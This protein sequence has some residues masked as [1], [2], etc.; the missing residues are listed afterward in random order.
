METHFKFIKKIKIIIIITALLAMGNQ[1][2]GGQVSITGK[3]TKIENNTIT[4]ETIKAET[5]PEGSRVDLFFEISEGQSIEV[6]QWK[7]SSRGKGV[8]FATPVDVTG[9]PLKGMTAKISYSEEKNRVQVTRQDHHNSPP[10]SQNDDTHEKKQFVYN[11]QQYVDEAKKIGDD[12]TKNSKKYSKEKNQ[13]LQRQLVQNVKKAVAADNAEAYYLLA[14]L[15]QNGIGEISRSSKKMV[16]NLM[17]SAKKGHDKAQFMLGDMYKRGDEVIKDKE[18]AIYWFQKAA[19]QGHQGAKMELE[20]LEPQIRGKEPS[21]KKPK[22]QL[23]GIPFPEKTAKEYAEAGDKYFYKKS[24]KMA[25]KEYEQCARMGN[26]GCQKMLGLF[27]NNGFGVEKDLN[28]ARKF[29]EDSARQNNFEAIYNLGLLYANGQGV[30]KN[31]TKARELFL[32]SA[33]LGYPEAQFNLGV[34]YY[35]GMGVKKR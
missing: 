29:Y 28:K 17:M 6:G 35:N 26:A 8:V 4:I 30:K 18:K 5:I 31:M 1:S 9:P 27:Y 34:L 22:G 20:L 23:L 3:V 32:Q 25:F 10:I 2:F 33:N 14:F 21:G 13:T 16:E 24:Y 12:L 19:D 11:P 15:H 7:V